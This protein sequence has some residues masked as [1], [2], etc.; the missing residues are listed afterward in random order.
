MAASLPS[1]RRREGRDVAANPQRVEEPPAAIVKAELAKININGNLVDEDLNTW[2][3]RTYT[4]RN[5]D[6]SYIA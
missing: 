3:A 6:L 4:A 1:G 5:F 2:A